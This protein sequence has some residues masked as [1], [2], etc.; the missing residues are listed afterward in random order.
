MGVSP[1]NVRSHEI[2]LT[3]QGKASA[4]DDAKSGCL[5]FRGKCANAELMKGP[6]R[7]ETNGEQYST[8]N[9]KKIKGRAFPIRRKKGTLFRRAIL[10]WG[11]PDT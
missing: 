5:G 11:K 7:R 9:H 8:R 4:P 10:H 3:M 6:P 1:V 2:L